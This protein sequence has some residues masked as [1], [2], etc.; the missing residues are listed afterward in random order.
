VS[1]ALALLLAGAAAAAV[2]CGG[3]DGDA[4]GAGGL[5]WVGEPQVTVSPDVPGVRIVT[6]RVRNE[7]LRRLELASS[8]LRLKTA[9]G[10]SLE[11]DFGFVGAY[12]R[13]DQPRNR[14]EEGLPESER[15]R[16]GLAARLEPGATTAITGSW[17]VPKRPA[18]ALRIDYRTG[19]LPIPSPK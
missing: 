17:R 12:V 7:S 4:S 14:S 1:R 9:E 11:A 10:Q 16:V 18:G 3:S 13:P 8:D 19:F 15:E 2:A 5:S 6:G